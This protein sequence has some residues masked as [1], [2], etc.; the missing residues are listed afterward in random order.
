M[1]E[2]NYNINNI[3]CPACKQRDF[4]SLEEINLEL[5]HKLYAPHNFKHQTTLTELSKI[6]G[7]KYQMCK[8]KNCGLEFSY[9]L[10]APNQDWYELTYDVL[11]LYPFD[12]WEFDFIID[13]IKPTDSVGEIGCGS[14]SF[15]SKCRELNLNCRGL[16]FSV[17]AIEK[18]LENNL[19]ADLINLNE[20]V[21][22]EE[23]KKYKPNVICSFH[24]LE[25]LDKPEN[26]FQIAYKWSQE[27]S[28]LWISVPSDK[29]GTRIFDEV[30]FLD[31]PPHHIT[32]WTPSSLKEIGYRNKW[33]LTDVIYEPVPLKTSL[34][35]YATR[36]KIYKFTLKNVIKNCIW[37]ERGFRYM[38][39][40]FAFINLLR[41]PEKISGFSMLIKFSKINRS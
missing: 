40:P 34:W 29:R 39:F 23:I 16:D 28:D 15:L 38:L 32:R 14:G 6:P 4:K 11:D 9:P 12:R 25:H 22:P 31:Q 2:F 8:C 20:T 19:K 17:S 37:I 41:T 7:N 5:Q 27:V 10:K 1:R 36:M 3:Y 35:F 33:R 21:I 24:T 26:L 30:D 18:C 13:N